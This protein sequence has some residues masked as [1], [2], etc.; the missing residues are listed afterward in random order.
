MDLTGVLLRAGATRPH[1]LAVTMPG[2]TA[3]RLAAEDY[4]RRRGLPEAMT[5]A[6]ADILL[7]CGTPVAPMAAAVAETWQA[8]PAPRARATA[9]RPAEVAGALGEAR[10]R[11]ADRDSQ[12][13]LAP[14]GARRA[15]RRHEI[16][17]ASWRER[18]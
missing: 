13:A 16:G 10:M 14:V 17:R 15:L 1:V 9:V 6:D 5:P 2:A 12:R 8:T 3:V 11:L 4:L 18:V 7:I